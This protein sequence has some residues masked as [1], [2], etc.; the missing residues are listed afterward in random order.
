MNEEKNFEMAA[1][2]LL[3]YKITVVCIYRSPDGNYK[4]FLRKLELVI[5]KLSVKRKHLI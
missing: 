2:E 1:I 4:E 3:E 5:K